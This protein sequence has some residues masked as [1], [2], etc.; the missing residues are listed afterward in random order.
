MMKRF[1][2]ADE[3]RR[4]NV[5]HFKRTIAVEPRHMNRRTFIRTTTAAGLGLCASRSLGCG[6]G[7]EVL[8]NGISLPTS[9][10]PQRAFGTMLR[11]PPYLLRPPAVIPIDVGRQLFVDDFLI[12]RTDLHRVFHLT[13]YLADT[14]VLQPDRSWEEAG[15]PTACAM[16]FS[17][18]VLYD[19]EDQLFKCWYM[20][21]LVQTRSTCL[22]LS[23]DGLRWTKPDW[24]VVR[25]TNI[26]WPFDRS[27]GRDSH[28]VIRD[29]ND[30]TFKF[31]MQS[32]GSG[33]AYTAQ[34]LLGSR[35]GVHWTQLGET[36][37]AGDRTTMFFNPFRD[38]W[39]YSLRVGGEVSGPPRH[40]LYQE[41]MRFVPDVWSPVFW[42][43]AD[44]ED[45]A[46]ESA[47][48]NPPQLYALD[49]VAYESVLLG[50]F[51]IFRGDVADRPKLNDVVW[52]VSRDGFHWWR[53][54]RRP[55]IGH[56]RPGAWNTGNVQSVGGC[57]LV[58]GDRLYFYVSGR[59]GI[60]GTSD[61]GVC[62]TGLAVLRRDGFASMV[63]D[64]TPGTLTTRPIRFTGQH[65][66]VNAALSRGEL[67]VEVL[68]QGGRV[69]EPFS[70]AACVP[71]TGDG[72]KQPVRWHR[73]DDVAAVVQMN[74]RL[75]FTLTR[76][77]LFSFWVSESTS[78]TSGGY[79]GA[80]SPSE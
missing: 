13:S 38:V 53:P 42:T 22:A 65:L 68:D 66:F 57:C 18:G 48:G 60:P 52:G 72:T 1:F 24:G 35:D 11:T 27:H 77:Q 3:K 30:D 40:R 26:V 71:I 9:W 39:V 49:C 59:Q 64:D 16:P 70:R 20:G 10:P 29:T 28:T 76:G 73:A 47:N 41:S 33:G 23:E 75:R 25:G 69:I 51:T 55:F 56:G 37:L 21:G 67:R 7:A 79:L 6:T 19:A 45:P 46:D 12:Q 5:E 58:V 61:H 50:L 8:Y 17:D 74:V 44:T 34:W 78:G 14:P 15:L 32:S 54:D 62:A 36:P 43:A 4:S 31:K 2:D 63:A 80:G